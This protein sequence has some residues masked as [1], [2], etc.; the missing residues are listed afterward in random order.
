MKSWS[1][2]IWWLKKQKAAVSPSKLWGQCWDTSILGE[3]VTRVYTFMPSPLCFYKVILHII[4]LLS[5]CYALMPVLANSQ[6]KIPVVI[7]CL[8]GDAGGLCLHPVP[9]IS[10]FSVSTVCSR[11]G[12]TLWVW[13]A[14]QQSC[15]TT[16][17]LGKD[18]MCCFRGEVR[19]MLSWCKS[20]QLHWLCQGSTNLNQLTM[21]SLF[22]YYLSQQLWD[23]LTFF[24]LILTEFSTLDR[25]CNP[26]S[27]IMNINTELFL[28]I[29]YFFW[30]P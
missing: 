11:S 17:A 9:C 13:G 14:S 27:F 25:T 6:D 1:G 3:V 21:W 5:L 15:W 8:Y 10:K 18:S 26:N 22:R 16:V 12:I 23:L 28:T 4:H 29:S 2:K 20:V 30:V 7:D 24:T 19:L